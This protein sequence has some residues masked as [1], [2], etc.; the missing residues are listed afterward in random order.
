MALKRKR[1]ANKVVEPKEVKK[2]PIGQD[3]GELIEFSVDKGVPM[4]T[5]S[6]RDSLVSRFPLVKMEVGDSFLVKKPHSRQVQNSLSCSIRQY[7]NSKKI[8][9]RYSVFKDPETEFIRVWR[10]T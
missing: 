2:A 4:P 9:H 7:C 5:K 6:E 3:K 8:K 1:G 10:S